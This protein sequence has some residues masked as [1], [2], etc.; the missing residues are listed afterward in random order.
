MLLTTDARMINAHARF[1]PT[2][3]KGIAVIAPYGP[4]SP[5]LCKIGAVLATFKQHLPQWPS[6]SLDNAILELWVDCPTHD[7]SVAHL[8]DGQVAC[9]DDFSYSS[10]DWPDN[11]LHALELAGNF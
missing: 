2:N 1:V 9:Y 7:V 11:F 10:P 6:L 5:D 4:T 3:H 8:K